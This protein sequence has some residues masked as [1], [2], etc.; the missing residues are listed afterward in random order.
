MP[1]RLALVVFVAS[2]CTV[3]RAEEPLHVRIDRA[4]EA[5]AA[6][7]KVPL[8][9]PADDAE[10]LRRA[11][12]DFAGR[13]PPAEVTRAFLADTDPDKRAKLLDTLFAGPDYA[14]RMADAFHVMFMERLGDN[15]EWTA[16]LTASF[17][18]N[19]PWD[20]MAREILRAD[21]KDEANRGASFFLSK[22]LDHYGQNPVE[23]S[24]LTRDVGRLFLGKNFQCCECHDHLFIPEYKQQDFQ[25]LH[26]FFKNTFLVNAAKLQV[27][28]K[29]TAEKTN[30]ASVFDKVMMT[31]GPALPGGAMVEIPVFP[32]GMEFA[33]PPDRKTNN[34]GVPKFSTLAAVSEKLPQA[35]NRDFTRNI[36]NRLW[37]LAMGRGLVHPLDLH[38]AQNFGQHPE[39]M[40]L[41]A[42]EF[43]A[44]KF[45]IRWFL[46]ELART[47][48]YQRSSRAPEGKQP[49]DPWF[50]A[51]AMEK[52]LSAEQILQTVLEATGERDR[53]LKETSALVPLRVKFLKAYAAQ[54]REH[55]NEIEPSLKAALFVSHDAAVLDLLKPRPGNL[56]DRLA[57]LPD[58]KAAEELYLAVLTRRPT[59]DEVDTAVKILKKYPDK[60]ADAAGRLVWAL[61]ASMEFGV[62]H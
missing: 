36:A 22:R 40:N 29:L 38:H 46:R 12:L 54:P 4:V 16:Y 51:T 30:Y 59:A 24:A 50:Y 5:K 18:K 15:P 17:Q 14:P 28:E 11:W 1:A 56:V 42:D 2:A 23:Y 60:K 21:P 13:I 26:A 53:L 6:A 61:L 52:R 48:A 34:P 3:A 37:F 10:F 8:S 7:E 62:N 39:L 41:L 33:E 25:G 55:E 20:Q 57:K 44:H 43:A 49:G 45:D 47:K 35:T 31:T 9:G 19:K 32:K 27:G 58:E